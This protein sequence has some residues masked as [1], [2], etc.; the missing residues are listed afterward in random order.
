MNSD[1]NRHQLLRSAQRR[2]E[3]ACSPQ[4]GSRRRGPFAKI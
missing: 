2:H 4:T 1:D 3:A